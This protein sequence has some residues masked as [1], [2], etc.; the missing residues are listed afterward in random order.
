MKRVIKAIPFTKAT[1]QYFQKL[2]YERWFATEGYSCFRGVFDNFEQAIESA[3]KTKPL[4]YDHDQLAK[5]YQ[6]MAELGNWEYSKRVITTYDYPVLF[7][8]NNILASNNINTIFDFG[9]NVGIHFYAYK[10]YLNLDNL[11]WTVCDVSAII[12]AGEQL[13]Q[14]REEQNLLFTSSFQ[15]ANNKNIFVASGSVQ[16]IEDFFLKIAHLC[17]KPIHIL[18][19]R[20]PIYAG[21]EFVTLQNGGQVFYPQYVFNHQSFVAKFSNLGYELIDI[22]EDR[23]DSCIIPFYPENSV[24]LYHGIYFK[25][26]HL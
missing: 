12:N 14:K 7:W 20:L 19:N 22:W 5:E 2:N 25:L 1:Y 6:R 21:K 13:A 23:V 3:P 4:G 24:P 17:T 26:R 11:T 9:G 18:L 10:K 8:L 15:D 16:Y